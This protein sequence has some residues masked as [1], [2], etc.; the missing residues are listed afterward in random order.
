MQIT[1]M[2]E[3]QLHIRRHG[4]VVSRFDVKVST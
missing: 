3:A 1:S 4:A 2:W